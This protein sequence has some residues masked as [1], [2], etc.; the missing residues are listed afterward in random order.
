[1]TTYGGRIYQVTAPDDEGRAVVTPRS[2]PLASSLPFEP[3]FGLAAA[4]PSPGDVQILVTMFSP[5]PVPL[6][7]VGA[8]GTVDL[9][10]GTPIGEGTLALEPDVDCSEEQC[11]FYWT[12]T[13][14]G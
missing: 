8:D 14:L 12:E 3:L 9:L 13:A 7:T 11:V 2:D 4:E 1:E 6:L 5:L 10:P